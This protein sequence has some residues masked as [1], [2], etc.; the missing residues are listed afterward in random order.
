MTALVLALA[1][2]QANPALPAADP[3]L[4]P[5]PVLFGYYRMKS[6]R[7][8]SDDLHCDGPDK[9]QADA[10]FDTIRKRLIDR[11]GKKA[12]SPPRGAPSGPGDC[13]V[14]MLVY[15]TNLD[16]YRTVVNAALSGAAPAVRTQE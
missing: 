10:E 5:A 6:F 14:V 1:T 16:D 12:F 9:R 2:V 7:D 4:P 8:R 11:Y 15:R 3:A 13:R